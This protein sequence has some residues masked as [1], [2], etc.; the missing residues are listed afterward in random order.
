MK[1]YIIASGLALAGLLQVQPVFAVESGSVACQSGDDAERAIVKTVEGIF[2]A[3]QNDDLVAFQKVVAPD[4][5]AYDAGARLT[6]AAMINLIKKAHAG[7]A[8]FEWNVTEPQVHI[9]CTTAWITYINQGSVTNAA[10]RQPLTWQE[11]ANLEYRDGRWKIV[12]LHSNR[13]SKAP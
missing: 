9:N 4:F 5:Y 13:V 8:V 10:G 3:G 6:A 12:F 7:G 2:T 11:S 1:S